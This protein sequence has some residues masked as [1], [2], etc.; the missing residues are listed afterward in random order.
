MNGKQYFCQKTL[1]V[2]ALVL[3]SLPQI[4]STA[5][6][7]SPPQPLA[8]ATF[9][10]SHPS[11]D[12]LAPYL[13]Q[14]A[15]QDPNDQVRVIVQMHARDRAVETA[16]ARTGGQI[17]KQLA[18]INA[19]VAD[20]KAG[21]LLT[22]AQAESVRAITLDAPVRK[23]NSGAGN[24]VHISDE[25]NQVSYAGSNGVAAWSTE[26]QEIGEA[27]GA[28]EGNVAVTPFWG[29]ALQGLRLQGGNFGAA[30]RVELAAAQNAQL[31]IAYRRK[32]LT[33][34]EQ[35]VTIAVSSDA[36]SS[37]QEVGRLSGP[38]TD[39]EIQY[40]YI[41]LSAFVGATLT[42]QF[43]TSGA[44]DESSKV[45]LD[46][47]DVS[48]TPNVP[49]APATKV[50]LPL[51]SSENSMPS[52]EDSATDDTVQAAVY[53]TANLASTY[54]KAIG[55]DRVWREWPSYLTGNNVR[56]A[57]VDSG[58]SEHP[59]LRKNGLS[60]IVARVN[61]GPASTN[62][63][64]DY[65][66]GTHVAGIMGGSG[67]Q[68]N[69]KYMGVAPDAKFVD[70]RVTD[71]KGAGSTSNLVNG[72][73]W[74]LNNKNTYNIRIVNMSINSSVPDSYLTSPLSAAV[75]IL[76]FNGIVVVVS[77]GNAGG[78]KLNPPANDPFVITV[79]AVDDLGTVST[80]DDTL[81][82]FSSYSITDDG[83][84][85][86]DLVAPGRNIV[87]LLSSDDNNLATKYPAN[88]LSGSE[89][90]Y[91]YKMSG[92]SMAAGV[93]SGAIAILLQKEPLLTPDQVKYRLLHTARPFTTGQS[94]A[95]GAGYLDIYAATRTNTSASAN[96]GLKV[97]QLLWTGS[98]PVT[99]SSV[100]WNSVSWNS[101]SW[102]SVSWNSVSWNSVSWNSV[103]WN[104]NESGGASQGSCSDVSNDGLLG[105]WRLNESGETSVADASGN[106][107]IGTT[108]GAI[109]SPAGRING[110][111]I[112][113]G[114]NDVV[115]IPSSSSLNSVTNQVTLSTWI[116]RTIAKSGWQNIVTRQYGTSNKDQFALALNNNA[117]AFVVNTLNNGPKTLYGGVNKVNE[118]VHLAGVYDGSTMHLYV[119]GDLVATM[120][121][122]TGNVR[123]E[124]KPLFFGGGADGVDPNAPSWFM[125]GLID[126]V[127]IYKRALNITEI[128]TIVDGPT[129]PG[130][131]VLIYDDGLAGGWEDWSWDTT[132]DFANTTPVLSG[133]RS[134]AVTYNAPWAGFY[135]HANTPVNTTGY[136]SLR[137]RVRGSTTNNILLAVCVNS[138]SYQY[139][140]STYAD[141]WIQ[142]D[143]PLTSF[144][145]PTAVSDIWWQNW[146]NT[147]QSTFYV[148]QIELVP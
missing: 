103:S 139:N 138:C 90:A 117:Y 74:V 73:E 119:D 125:S 101:V 1:T 56:I 46:F 122:V 130:E 76:W 82:K 37:W 61:F 30:R 58:I 106:K 114:L 42:L 16:V 83:F 51:V 135:L 36:G 19:F 48:F 105:H 100:S 28:A 77:A 92:T 112:L 25:F 47:I 86:P 110:A 13:R 24:Q 129:T 55:A 27:D 134:I 18:L 43:V 142:I 53:S 123:M 71:D 85:K 38:A 26:W 109:R 41:N 81:A 57:V 80:T 137:F 11:T 3:I 67:A 120:P 113:D 97:N 22:L 54:V 136:S 29:G 116:Y 5:A 98:N 59:D 118:W 44:M 52:A 49:V 84:A 124:G 128:K 64:D 65:G 32:D 31:S 95:A 127:R 35:F 9:A 50:Y 17:V 20:V 107:N 62:P 21:T 145:N 4:V 104:S 10:E 94:C 87:S 68:S 147:D 133:S 8:A 78:G 141:Q 23:Q 93:V 111:V 40:A 131:P 45:Y 6:A 99:W 140:V 79:G 108:V 75:E 60:R 91:Y 7:L 69:G 15:V 14:L 132:R 34:A 2:I 144:G 146:N 72:L 39:S 121:G 89:G 96:T 12:R 66:H 33:N 63:D 115:T 126:D 148:D 102:N 70:V 143:V 88:Q